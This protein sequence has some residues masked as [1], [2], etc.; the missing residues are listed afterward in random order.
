MIQIP[1]EPDHKH[2]WRMIMASINSKRL[3]FKLT[4]E[5]AQLLGLAAKRGYSNNALWALAL[6]AHASRQ[7]KAVRRG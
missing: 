6:S 2:L 1:G 5:I 7:R 4:S 3:P